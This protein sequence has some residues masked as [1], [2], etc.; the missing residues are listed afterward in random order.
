MIPA[1][2]K[3]IA[4]ATLLL[5]AV[6]LLCFSGM[7]AGAAATY[8]ATTLW[9]LANLVVWAFVMKI[10]L[11]P[12]TEKPSLGIAATAILGKMVLLFG[13]IFALR[14]FAPYSAMQVYG[15]LAGVSSVL[16]VAFLKAAGAK[17]LSLANASEGKTKSRAA[18]V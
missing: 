5:G 10:V 8:A 2:I 9:M 1:R 4:N 13:G 3:Q 14:F 11:Q 12:G 17:V 6:V 15:I 16:A 7:D 18:K